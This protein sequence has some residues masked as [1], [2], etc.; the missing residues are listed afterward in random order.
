MLK[1]IAVGAGGFIGA[2]AR[3]GISGLVYRYFNGAFPA[4]TLVVNVLGCTIIGALMALVE[5]RQMLS[6]QLRL[7]LTIGLLGSFTTFSTVAFETFEMLRARDMLLAILNVSANVA[8]GVAAVWL[9][10]FGVRLLGV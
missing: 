3:Y 1:L 8:I 6:P 10:R 9:G 4:G 2:V 5:E 7:F